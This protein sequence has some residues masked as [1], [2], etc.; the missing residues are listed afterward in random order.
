MLLLIETIKY[1]ASFDIKC[2]YKCSQEQYSATIVTVC[3]NTVA[4][5][6]NN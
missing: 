2:I 6:S 4:Y 1:A 5:S 3:V